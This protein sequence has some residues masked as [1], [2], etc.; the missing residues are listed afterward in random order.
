M[1]SPTNPNK[2]KKKQKRTSR[3]MD[4]EDALDYEYDLDLEMDADPRVSSK[5]LDREVEKKIDQ[6]LHREKRSED[7]SAA[8]SVLDTRTLRVLD[9][10]MRNGFIDPDLD[11][12]TISTGKEAI[13]FYALNQQGD[14]VAVKIYRTVTS[15]FKRREPYLF[16][17]PRFQTVKKTTHSIV[18]AWAQKEYKNLQKA[19][20]AGIKVP[21]P[22]IVRK[23]VLVIEFIGE[24][25][26]PAR[27][28]REVS[29]KNPLATFERILDLVR[30][31]YEEADLVHADLSEY[32]ILSWQDEPVLI[33]FAQAVLTAH[34]MSALF[35]RR[36]L[37]NISNYFSRFGISALA[38][39]ESLLSDL[40]E[41]DEF[42]GFSSPEIE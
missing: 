39:A 36:D 13:V 27:L 10:L 5:R 24:D 42:I 18:Y 2:S 37:Q 34:P 17:D 26:V 9:Y 16:G 22:I 30:I 6:W 21:K 35:L 31:L 29:L 40:L 11:L 8:G 7:R 14:E 12:S 32:N 23:N 1:G 4:E 3:D 25:R 38:A 19:F 15:D 20:N 33:D 28:L 41:E